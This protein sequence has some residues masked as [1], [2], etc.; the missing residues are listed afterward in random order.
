[1]AVAESRPRTLGPGDQR[2]LDLRHAP[3]HAATAQTRLTIAQR[4]GTGASFVRPPGALRP[5]GPPGRTMARR[6]GPLS[7][8]PAG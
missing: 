6:D 3:L 5:L 1:M 8:P 7:R 2:C 4:T